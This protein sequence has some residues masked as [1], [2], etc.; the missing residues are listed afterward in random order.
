MKW[1]AILESG[2]IG[3]NNGVQALGGRHML[4][5]A[6]WG[7]IPRMRVE[8]GL[9]PRENG[10]FSLRMI[11]LHYANLKIRALEEADESPEACDDPIAHGAVF[12]ARFYNSARFP[13]AKI[14]RDP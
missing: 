6:T 13:A 10:L 11:S 1:S 5:D 2:R 14:N 8:G 4:S 9:R 7:A 3:S 12:G